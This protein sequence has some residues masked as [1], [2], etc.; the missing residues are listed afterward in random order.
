M[1]KLQKPNT[2]KAEHNFYA[3]LRMR[4]GVP[5]ADW[6][7]IVARSAELMVFGSR[8]VQ[9]N[10]T[11]SDLDVLI[12]A[13]FR[14]RPKNR[15]LDVVWISQS[16]LFSASWLESEL[17]SH[18]AR[19]GICLKGNTG[20][21]RQVSI[22]SRALDRKS[23]RISSLVRNLRQ[24]WTRLHPLFKA[25]YKTTIRRELQRLSLLQQGIPT[26]PTPIL[27]AEWH[28]GQIA[29]VDLLRIVSTVALRAGDIDFVMRPF[30]VDLEGRDTSVQPN[31]LG[32]L[33]RPMH[34]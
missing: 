2:K 24:S 13:D 7:D 27:D 16:E 32:E 11:V 14:W 19:Y 3:Q 30:G 6:A 23:R 10:R 12:V 22:G 25:R 31:I 34:N 29:A 8:A 5:S 20:W 28:S 17:A 4:S 33:R 15:Q 21:C 18:I 1:L 9:V 26:P